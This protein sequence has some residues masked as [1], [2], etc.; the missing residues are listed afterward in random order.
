[1]GDQETALTYFQDALRLDIDSGQPKNMADSHT[2]VANVLKDLGRIDWPVSK[3]HGH[4]AGDLMPQQFAASLQQVFRSSDYLGRWSG[5]EFVVV[6]RFTN[7][8]RAAELAQPLLDRIPTTGKRAS[9]SG[10]R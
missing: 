5:E 9:G 3:S 10:S 6:S 4:S 7:R 2:K 1:M 8:R